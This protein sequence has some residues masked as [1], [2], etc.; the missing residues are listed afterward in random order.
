MTQ[1]KK[2]KNIKKKLFIKF[3]KNYK[4]LFHIHFVKI[5]IKDLLYVNNKKNIFFFF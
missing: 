4:D 3:L 2:L 1:K 5:M